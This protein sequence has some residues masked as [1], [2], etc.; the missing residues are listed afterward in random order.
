MYK[1]QKLTLAG[2]E[3]ETWWLGMIDNSVGVGIVRLPRLT[4]LVDDAK[5][6]TWVV[7]VVVDCLRPLL[8]KDSSTTIAGWL[9]FRSVDA[10]PPLACAAPL[11]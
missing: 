5:L 9:A 6:D 10:C 7:Q 3:F 8:G 4:L 2:L 11:P 1:P